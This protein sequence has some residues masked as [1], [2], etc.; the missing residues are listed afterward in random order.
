MFRTAI[1]LLALVGMVLPASLVAVAAP[2]SA[3]TNAFN[4]Q[5]LVSDSSATPEV[6]V[7]PSLVNGWGLSAGPTTPWWVSD[8]GTNL[9]TLYSGTGA[10]TALTVTVP[11]GPTGT[12]FNGSAADFVVSQGGTSG[13]ARFLFA[14]EGGAI[15][16][17]TPAV[18]GTAAVVGADRSSAGA[19]YKGLAV[20]N[21]RLYATDFH[22]GRVDVFDASFNLVKTAGSF[23]DPK[24][25]KGFA[26]FGIQVLEGNVFVT[27]AQQDKARKDDVPVPGKAY[28]DE[29]TPDGQLVARVVNS[30]KPNAPLVAPWGLALAP[31][32]FGVFGGDL[33]VGNF[34]NGRVSAY[35]KRGSVWVYKGQLHAGDGKTIVIDG[36]W[37]IAFGN[38]SA[39]GPT[40]TLYFA[41]GPSGE[42]HGLF[43]SIVA[44]G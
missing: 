18:N 6:T 31:A 14:T 23:T 22:N 27:Y 2:A 43:G 19:L 4:V 5:P 9:S 16:G 34:G 28:V 33:L 7:D 37:A 44:T 36:L 32:D 21:D 13:A 12:V 11:G 40:N 20:T 1:R 10:K 3:A 30:G 29:F 41:A 17:W 25:A 39:A 8:N 24:I 35:T 15:L 38:G 26:P 42:R